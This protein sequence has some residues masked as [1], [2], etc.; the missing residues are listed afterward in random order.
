MP[1]AKAM[2]KKLILALETGKIYEDINITFHHLG[3]AR[4][5]RELKKLYDLVQQD[6]R[7][8]EIGYAIHYFDSWR[9]LP[10]KGH[11]R[12]DDYPYDNPNYCIQEEDA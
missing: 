12:L 1:I 7:A 2:G 5:Y 9:R 6:D 11:P 10:E 8:G 3:T 4:M